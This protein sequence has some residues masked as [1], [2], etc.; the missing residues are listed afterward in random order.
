MK[1]S[2]YF[3]SPLVRLWGSNPHL[4]IQKSEL[5][6]IPTRFRWLGEGDVTKTSPPPHDFSVH[7]YEMQE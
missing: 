3:S 7:S 6:Q 1:K 5:R 4:L 2:D